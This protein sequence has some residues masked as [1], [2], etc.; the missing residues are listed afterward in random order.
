MP[1]QKNKETHQ[2]AFKN[3]PVMS[4]EALA[5]SEQRKKEHEQASQHVAHGTAAD[6]NMT[7]EE[8]A[9]MTEHDQ[10]HAENKDHS[11]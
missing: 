1:R 6:H 8:H 2:H 5:E 4:E 7:A 10:V 9:A 3:A 11:H